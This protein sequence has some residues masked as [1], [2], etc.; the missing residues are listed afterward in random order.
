MHRAYNILGEEIARMDQED[1][2]PPLQHCWLLGHGHSAG[3]LS[4]ERVLVCCSAVSAGGRG[5]WTTTNVRRMEQPAWKIARQTILRDTWE[6]KW[7]RVNVNLLNTNSVVS[8][9]CK[10]I[11]VLVCANSFH[12]L[13]LHDTNSCLFSILYLRKLH[14]AYT[15][16]KN[17]CLALTPKKI[18]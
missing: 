7:R 10:N 13:K 18:G 3:N 1:L 2:Q 17:G 11:Q 8:F 5:F 6:K 15:R 16:A 14:R 9:M 12:I 4:W